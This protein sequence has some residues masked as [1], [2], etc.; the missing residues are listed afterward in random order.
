LDARQNIFYA[1]GIL[2]YALA[3]SDGDIQDVEKER[4]F[5][6]VK[7][8]MNHDI[9]FQYAEIIFQLLERDEFGFEK[10]YQWAMK[11]LQKG[12]HYLSPEIKR[13]MVHTLKQIAM[14]FNK[15]SSEESSFI[16]RFEVDLE[17]IGSDR[18][19]K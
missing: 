15:F 18:Y 3:K 9:D 11:E 16:N 6:M 8:E 10:T 13:K 17:N 7:K 2:A 12:R 4:L 1:L 14:A 19:L 5:E